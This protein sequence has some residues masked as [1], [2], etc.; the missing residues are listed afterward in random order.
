MGNNTSTSY[1]DNVDNIDK[2]NIDKNENDIYTLTIIYKNDS[3]FEYII[4]K[5]EY[6]EEI[7]YKILKYNLSTILEE[8][9]DE[10]YDEDM[11]NNYDINKL[12]FNDNNFYQENIDVIITITKYPDSDSDFIV[13]TKINKN[14]TNF[15][16]EKVLTYMDTIQNNNFSKKKNKKKK[17]KSNRSYRRRSR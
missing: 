10:D 11:K 5:E 16:V 9:Y 2:V 14:L 3:V 17:L 1:Y 6:G 4:R 12:S 7:V 13:S 8:D 15:I